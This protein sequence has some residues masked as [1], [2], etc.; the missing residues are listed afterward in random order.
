MP[1]QAKKDIGTERKKRTQKTRKQASKNT[2]THTRTQVRQGRMHVREEGRPTVSRGKGRE[3]RNAE[4]RRRV[5]S[6]RARDAR[7]EGSTATSH[8][9]HNTTTYRKRGGTRVTNGGTTA[10]QHTPHRH[11]TTST[12]TPHRHHIH[13]THPSPAAR[14][15]DGRHTHADIPAPTA[16]ERRALP[17]HPKDGQLGEGERLT[18]GAP[19]QWRG[20]PPP[21]TP[22]RHPDSAQR[23]LARADAVGPVLGPHAHTNRARETRVTEPQLPAP[24][25]GRPGK[26]QRLTPDAPH[27]S[28]RPPPEGRPPTSTAARSFPQG[29]QA[30]GTGLGPNVRTPAPTA[31]G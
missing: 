29:M 6:S 20:V 5:A 3:H 26:G 9:K 14:P 17:A 11:A 1:P 24:R 13:H 10:P 19:S 16:S 12:Q 15:T 4:R 31:S 22:S 25:D 28:G 7:G 30:K 2:K 23:R 27:N 21:G 8:G 18:P